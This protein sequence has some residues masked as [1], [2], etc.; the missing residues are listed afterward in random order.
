[1]KTNNNIIKG[2]LIADSAAA[3]AKYLNDFA[4]YMAANGA[5]LYSVSVQNEPDWEPD[6]EGCVWTATEMRDFLKNQGA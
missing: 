2:K 6:Y 3:Y 1:M 4:I 5:P